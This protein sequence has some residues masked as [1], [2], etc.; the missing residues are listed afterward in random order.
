MKLYMYTKWTKNTQVIQNVHL[1]E[2]HKLSIDV[3]SHL[4]QHFSG[5][6]EVSS[7]SHKG[8]LKSFNTAMW[9]SSNLA[10]K[11]APYRKIQ[12]VEIWRRRPLGYEAWNIFS[13][14][15]LV[16]NWSMYRCTVLLKGPMLTRKHFLTS[17]LHN[18]IQNE[19]L[20]HKTWF[21]PN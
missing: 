7:F 4:L 17:F 9:G 20:Y 12:R 1:S 10:L 14:P 21:K 8:L 15:G 6:E 19:V 3:E 2:I 18:L 13:Q 11:N 16:R 5:S